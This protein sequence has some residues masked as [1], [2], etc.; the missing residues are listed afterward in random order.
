MHR[1][2]EAE[3]LLERKMVQHRER[4]MAEVHQLLD[5]F[6]LRP[7]FASPTTVV[8]HFLRIGDNCI[9]FCLGWGKWKVSAKVKSE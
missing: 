4:K 3:E 6:E 2:A 9:S 5:A 8:F 1:I 7:R